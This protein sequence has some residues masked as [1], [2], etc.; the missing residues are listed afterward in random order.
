EASGR[1]GVLAD[2]GAVRARG[3]AAVLAASSVTAQGHS[4]FSTQPVSPVLVAAQVRAGRELGP[5][6]AVKLGVGPGATQL[7]AVRRA[8]RGLDI[9]WV[10][11]PVVRSSTGGRLSTL[12]ARSYR[13]LAGRNVWITPNAAEAGWLLGTPPVRTVGEARDAARALVRLGFGG[14]G[15]E[16]GGPAGAPAGGGGGAGGGSRGFRAFPGVS[17][18][19]PPGA[20]GARG[21]RPGPP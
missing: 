21:A 10:V 12:S 9:P 3:G 8:L 18:A 19:P 15:G 17:A 20:P 7:G 6:H 13:A 5:V 1:V 16:G 2:A 11:D 14:G 4:T